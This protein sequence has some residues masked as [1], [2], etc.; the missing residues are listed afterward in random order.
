MPLDQPEEIDLIEF[1]VVDGKVVGGVNFVVVFIIAMISIDQ[2]DMGSEIICLFSSSM[3][4]GGEMNI[5][6][7]P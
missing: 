1:F 3:R 5:I 7:M 4:I 6:T 2:S